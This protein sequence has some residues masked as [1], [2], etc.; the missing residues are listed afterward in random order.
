LALPPA[1]SVDFKKKSD[2]RITVSRAADRPIAD[3][4]L[5][6]LPQP[7]PP[8]PVPLSPGDADLTLDLQATLHTI[9]DT[10]R[11]ERRLNYHYNRPPPPPELPA[12]QQAWIA[13]QIAAIPNP[14]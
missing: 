7:L 14:S 1:A 4:W 12:D 10:G 13:R 2:Y 11:Y 5:I 8:V 6:D 9:Y 3:W